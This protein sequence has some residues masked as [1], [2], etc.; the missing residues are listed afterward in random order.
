[1]KFTDLSPAKQ[2]LLKAFTEGE[3]IQYYT[4]ATGWKD[5]DMGTFFGA[6]EFSHPDW[7][8]VKTKEPVVTHV[9]AGITD[10]G[11]I[12]AFEHNSTKDLLNYY[13]NSVISMYIKR[14]F[15]DGKFIKAEIVP[16]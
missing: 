12:L 11:R 1:M 14:T 7:L 13:S 3:I 9:Y 2:Q 6:L 8:R 4:P 5:T 10:E 16:E 15:H